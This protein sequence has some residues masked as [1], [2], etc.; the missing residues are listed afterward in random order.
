MHLVL[1]KRKEKEKKE[2]RSI[3]FIE[4]L[5]LLKVNEIFFMQLTNSIEIITTINNKNKG[6]SKTFYRKN[7]RI[8]I[9]KIYC[10]FM[11]NSFIL[12]SF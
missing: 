4:I 12:L 3:I 8:E 9:P 5:Y 11:Q 6:I 7:Q 1:R 10:Y 2:I